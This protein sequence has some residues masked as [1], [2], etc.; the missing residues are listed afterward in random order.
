MILPYLR[1]SIRYLARQKFF[2]ALHVIGLTLGVSVAIV[3]LIFIRYE[4]SFD[5]SSRK[6][7]RTYRVNSS[8]KVPGHQFE[9]YATP[10]ALPAVVRQEI[11]GVEQLAMVFPQFKSTV[12]ITP[13]RVFS[14]EHIL[15]AEASFIDIFDVQILSGDRHALHTPYQALISESTA[16]KFFGDA[17]P[18]G[19]SFR[20]R[21]KYDLNIAGVFRDMPGNSSLPASIII[22]YLDDQEFVGNNDTWYFGGTEWTTINAVTFVVLEPQASPLDI[23][24]KFD[25]IANTY[26]NKVQQE[27]HCTFSLQALTDIHLD[28]T[29]FGGGPW[30]KAIDSK[31]LFIFGGIG[32]TV[33]L[34]ACV[35][36]INLST[37]QA[38]VRSREA[39]I[40][41][42]IGAGRQQLVIQFLTEPVLLIVVSG[43]FAIIGAIFMTDAV[44]LAFGKHIDFSMFTTPA[45][46]ILILTVL[47][48]TGLAAGL[49]PAWLIARVNPVASL[50]PGTQRGGATIPWLRKSLVVF[51]FAISAVL[52]TIVLVI[53]RQV[54]YLHSKDIG[55]RK[56]GVLIINVPGD[57]G[58]EPFVN[59]AKMIGGVEGVSLSRS[60]PLSNDHWWNTMGKIT[61]PESE[62]VCIISADERYTELYDLRL[63]SG[64]IPTSG[65]TLAEVHQVIVNQK[66]L[67]ILDLGTPNEAIGKRFKWSGIAEVTGVIADFNSEPLHYGLVPTLIYQDPDVYSH[68]NIRLNDVADLSVLGEIESAWKS[69]FPSESW[70]PKILSDQINSYYKTE[71]TTYSTFFV[72]AG[73][74]VLISC[75]G[76][77]GLCV[78]TT[79]R[80]TKEISIRKALGASVEKIL[81]LLSGHFMKLIAFGCIVAIPMAWWSIDFLLSFYAFRINITWDLLLI[82]IVLLIAIAFVT[83]LTQ[84][85]RA[86]LADPVKNLRSE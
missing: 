57:V 77:L 65:D 10:G 64:R 67:Q 59:K 19:K 78:F 9:I 38:I 15:I 54:D 16:R 26:V 18:L 6:A 2:T 8:F 41:K 84:T 35:N 7:D 3:V 12:A 30:V 34:L 51:Q 68:A 29:R 40:R 62:S 17:D 73:I 83:M 81:I 21:G 80:R 37:A 20:Y 52:M 22:S 46:V 71:S 28:A 45:S 86:S 5:S 82:P 43:F 39:G 56:D 32:I 79:A 36:F 55:F 85:V 31:W 60:A 72:F 1:F 47:I 24:P 76:L 42:T 70:E 25:N 49:Y 27:V 13:E 44:N 66:L 58:K 69:E 75:L 63:L 48:L 23:Q 11:P 50:K 14:Q 4:L 74:A 61:G 33:L 53:A